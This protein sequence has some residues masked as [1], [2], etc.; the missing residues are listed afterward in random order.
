MSAAREAAYMILM[1][2]GAGRVFAVDLLQRDEVSRLSDPDRRLTTEIV[3]GVLRWQGALDGEIESLS[4]KPL[5]YF[6][7]EILTILRMAVY[8]IL[9]LAKIPGAPQ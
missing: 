8:Q 9:F 2:V 3:M 1:R 4:G 5:K 6:D 7:S